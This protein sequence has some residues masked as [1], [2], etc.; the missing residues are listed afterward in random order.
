[1]TKVTIVLFFVTLFI[2]PLSAKGDNRR[3]LNSLV[4]IASKIEKYEKK[5]KKVKQ[6][7]EYALSHFGKK[8]PETLRLKKTLDYL[9]QNQ[10]LMQFYKKAFPVKFPFTLSEAT[11]R[12]ILQNSFDYSETKALSER[13]KKAYLSMDKLFQSKEFQN[14]G[15]YSEEKA[16]SEKEMKSVFKEIEEVENHIGFMDEK[17]VDIMKK[18]GPH[19]YE[20]TEALIKGSSRKE[21]E[22]LI[23]SFS[24]VEDNSMILEMGG[25][26]KGKELLLRALYH[27]GRLLKISSEQSRVVRLLKNKDPQIR[28]SATKLNLVRT[29]LSQL[30]QNKDEKTGSADYKKK[31]HKLEKK[32]GELELKLY[33]KIPYK[34]LKE[35]KLKDI[36]LPKTSAL[37]EIVR[38]NEAHSE[39]EG[40]KFISLVLSSKELLKK[41]KNWDS[42]V[43]N[44]NDKIK[45][46]QT[47]SEEE[48]YLALVLRGD[49]KQDVQLIKLG[50]VKKIDNAIEE[51]QKLVQN[52]KEN[53]STIT[54]HAKAL[55]NTLLVPVLEKLKGI[56]QIYFS[57]DGMLNLLPVNALVSPSGKYVSEELDIR[58]L[59]SGRD[60]IRNSRKTANGIISF[61]APKYDLGRTA[62]PTVWTKNIN[63][64]TI[65]QIRYFQPLDKTK[66]EATA[67][68]RTF[69]EKYTNEISQ[70]YFGAQATEVQFKDMPFTPR[71]LYIATHSFFL[72][73][74]STKTLPSKNMPVLPKQDTPIPN[75]LAHFGLA[76]A[77]SNMN[78]KA[79]KGTPDVEDGILTAM[80]VLGLDLSGTKLV[81]LNTCESGVGEV[82]KGEGI[83]GLR[84][85]F[86]EAGARMVLTTLW[87][88]NDDAARELM[89]DFFR[90]WLS[91]TSA[92]EALRKAKLSFINSKDSTRSN[93]AIWA[94]FVLVGEEQILKQ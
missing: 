89:G 88:V 75:S 52:E 48:R 54:A 76:L 56:K 84:R 83:Y 72:K 78:Q 21:R 50:T 3:K 85:A 91:G 1:M 73:N 55:Y 87:E 2:S 63:R 27:K 37:V 80:E 24:K 33:R 59:S 74:N 32:E 43:R 11:Q 29:Q 77:G 40:K 41:T 66:E 65:D 34:K 28:N 14:T 9:Y 19:Q 94:P 86:Q 93:P 35:I 58:I 92:H 60:L 81:I 30:I 17:F 51:Y 16:W 22:H 12:K 25:E 18:I 15:I 53:I 46:L 13:R 44:L 61:A 23:Q 10:G 5:I 64:A 70:S 42:Q 6:D 71:I 62:N 20:L 26:G 8:H 31:L 67:L 36:I 45:S 7:Y 69:K 90:R 49:N 79:I 57:P 47:Q 68:I 82:R 39:K 38:Y 4:A